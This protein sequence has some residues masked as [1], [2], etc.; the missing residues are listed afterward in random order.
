MN[1]A[2][3]HD[4]IAGQEES[5]FQ[6]LETLEYFPITYNASKRQFRFSRSDGKNPTSTVLD[7]DSLR[8]YC[9]STNDKG[10]IFT[11][12]MKRMNCSFRDSL[13]IAAT[14]L[15]LDADLLNVNTRYPFHGFYRALMPDDET[16]FDVDPIPEEA[17]TP[18]LGKL[19]TQFFRSGISYTTQELF[20]VGY[21][22]TA[23]RITV[24]ERNFA[25]ELCGIMGRSNDPNCAHEDR[26][27][28]I[29]ACPRSKT[30]FGLTQNYQNIVERRSVFLYESEKAPMQMH[31]MG[32]GLALG[33]CGCHVS[34]AQAAMVNSMLPLHIVLAL[35]E[36]LEEEAIREEAK[37]LIQDNPI[38]HNKVGYVWD[39]DGDIIPKG[40]KM[41]P[42]DLGRDAYVEII[43]KKVRWVNG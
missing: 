9:F 25:G 22:E 18:Y 8:F 35:D 12:I 27:L 14:I 41:N 32:C 29:V 13:K 19:N 36:G 7:C 5:V 3:L 10:D 17:L 34:K 30:L 37:K 11:L 16:N 28:P 21:D 1:A 40:S 4:Q 6:I 39:A 20:Q 23:G 31:S 33:L 24:P 42:A 2:L 26:W 15:N 43:K 38:L